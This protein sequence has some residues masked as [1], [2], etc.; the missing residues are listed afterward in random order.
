MV[1]LGASFDTPEDNAAF[2]RKFDFPFPLLCDEQRELGLA[3]GACQ[4]PDAAAAKR[5]TAVIG[6]DGNVLRVYQN[7]DAK[8]HPQQ[9]LQ[10]LASG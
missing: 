10:D 1:I 4:Q 2:K 9:V 8:S 5:I 6:P 3:F 7:V